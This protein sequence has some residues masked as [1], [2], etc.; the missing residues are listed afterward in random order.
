VE[1][2]LS[3]TVYQIAN[4]RQRIRG[5]SSAGANLAVSPAD[6]AGRKAQVLLIVPFIPFG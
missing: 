2:Q 3:S 6:P 5:R 1:P 4:A